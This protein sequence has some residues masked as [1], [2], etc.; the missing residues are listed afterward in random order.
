MQVKVHNEDD[1]FDEEDEPDEEDSLQDA[2]VAKLRKAE[3]APPPRLLLYKPWEYAENTEELGVAQ[4][5]SEVG[6]MM[7]YVKTLR[8]EVRKLHATIRALQPTANAP[9]NGAPGG[10]S[11]GVGAGAGVAVAPPGSPQK[12]ADGQNLIN[13][14]KRR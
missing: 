11:N 14:G 8:G 7:K 5:F 6:D 9:P 12:Q 1:D 4:V 3:S 2:H 13:T 10:G